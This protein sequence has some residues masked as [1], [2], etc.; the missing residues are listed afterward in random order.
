[1]P[2][3]LWGSMLLVLH[4][5]GGPHLLLWRS[6]LL[7][8]LRRFLQ[9]V[10]R[11]FGACSGLPAG[12]LLWL[13]HAY[14][15]GDS[16]APITLGIVL[17]KSEWSM[18]RGLLTIWTCF[19]PPCTA[20]K[21]GRRPTLCFGHCVQPCTPERKEPSECLGSILG[22][23][24]A[25]IAGVVTFHQPKSVQSSR[26]QVHCNVQEPIGCLHVLMQPGQGCAPVRLHATDIHGAARGRT[27]L[28]QH[29]G[30]TR[31]CRR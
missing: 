16:A 21:R 22:D 25:L 15:S 17:K 20:G 12:V 28:R 23:S 10:M 11:M 4:S 5:S 3:G 14:L 30:V 13:G 7:S 26:S 19:L 9:Q 2:C 8:C 24:C 27:L 6:L 31:S 1:M 29:C 18:D